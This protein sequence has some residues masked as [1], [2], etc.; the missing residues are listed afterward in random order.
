MVDT[1]TANCGPEM[2]AVAERQQD[3]QQREQL[4]RSMALCD[5]DLVEQVA[6]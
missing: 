2:S 4:V 5:M 3:Q 6:Y 1:V